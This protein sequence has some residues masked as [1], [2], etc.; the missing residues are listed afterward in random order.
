MSD[1]VFAHGRAWPGR[2]VEAAFA[3]AISLLARRQYRT[4]V[5]S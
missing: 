4:L 1:T 3:K 2:T 5:A